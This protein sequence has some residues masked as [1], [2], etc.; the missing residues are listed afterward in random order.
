MDVAA[1]EVFKYSEYLDSL[2]RAKISNRSEEEFLK[3]E[4]RWLMVVVYYCPK[5]MWINK[6][7]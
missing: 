7:Y 2:T 6:E 5:K 4:K 1:V 3:R